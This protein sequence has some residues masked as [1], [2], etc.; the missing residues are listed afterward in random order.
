MR[1]LRGVELGQRPAADRHAPALGV[2]EPQQDVRHGRLPGARRADE[3][4]RPALRDLERAP[5][6]GRPRTVVV[7][8]DDVVEP[9]V[10][11]GRQRAGGA[12]RRD[13]DPR[14][15]V[16]DGVD[17]FGGRRGRTPHVVLGRQAAQRQEELGREQQ[18][19]ERPLERQ[20]AG[21]Q[22]DAG[23]DRDERG[24]RGRAPLQ[25]ERRLER[26]AQDVHR[27]RTLP[28]AHGAD[29]LGLFGA[30]PEHLQRREPPQDVEEVG[31]HPGQLAFAAFGEVADAA[32]DQAEQQ[33]EHRARDQQDQ[34]GPRVEHRDD[35]RH[36]DRNQDGEDARG[37][38]ARDVRVEG[39]DPFPGRVDELAD[40]L[41]LGPPWG[42]GRRARPRA[43]R[44]GRSGCRRP[45]AGRRRRSTTAAPLGRPRA[46]ASRAAGHRPTRASRRRRRRAR[47]RRTGAARTRSSRRRPR[48]RARPRR[49]RFGARE[50]GPSRGGARPRPSYRSDASTRIR[51]ERSCVNPAQVQSTTAFARSS[52]GRQERQVDRAPREPRRGPGQRP[53]PAELH[54]GGL[55]TDR[56]HRA[57]VLVLER[58]DL[59]LLQDPARSSSPACSPACSATDPSCGRTV[60]VLVSVIHAMSPTPNTSG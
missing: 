29:R 43:V 3:R 19:R 40:P 48:P 32:S 20:P 6:E 5:G 60:L 25:H 12:R 4:D 54:H 55:A 23:L 21:H 7:R 9:D 34:H 46:R 17:A 38:V 30:A 52:P 10:Q 50:G 18:H 14:R 13:V 57:L 16:E 26:G 2:D 59:L 58:L 47:S 44:A 45:R 11:P 31:V 15:R 35:D 28:A 36:Q 53:A 37:D 51:P 22:P 8:H 27:A 41:A 49:P 33:H 56:R 24:G 1:Q 42:R 39:I